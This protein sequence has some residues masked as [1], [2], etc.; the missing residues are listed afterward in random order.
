[1]QN[2]TAPTSSEPTVKLINQLL[3]NSNSQSK[4]E[5]EIKEYQKDYL[6]ILIDYM[7][8][9]NSSEKTL[10]SLF[11]YDGIIDKLEVLPDQNHID[12]TVVDK[13]KNIIETYRKRLIKNV[14]IYNFFEGS[15]ERVDHTTL[16]VSQ[17]VKI[18]EFESVAAVGKPLSAYLEIIIY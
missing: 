6:N 4:K 15:L 12:F 14:V 18:K 17:K 9:P 10:F 2:S 11:E 16:A 3:L 7:Q 13:N 5:T 1:M 8:N